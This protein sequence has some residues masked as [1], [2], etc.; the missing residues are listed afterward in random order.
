MPCALPTPT[1]ARPDLQVGEAQG[2]TAVVRVGVELD[3]ATAAGVRLELLDALASTPDRLVVDLSD[4][5]FL[6]ATGAQLLLSAHLRAGSQGTRMTLRGCG[7][8]ARWVLRLAALHDVLEQESAPDV[9]E[10]GSYAVSLPT[11]SVVEAKASSGSAS[12]A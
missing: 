10:Q 6:G 1:P 2:S 5:P 7:P 8:Q 4:C 11:T 12:S 9:P 3:L